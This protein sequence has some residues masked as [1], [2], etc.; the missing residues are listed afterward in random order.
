MVSNNKFM[1]LTLPM[2]HC[3]LL[4]ITC[5]SSTT[6]YQARPS[7]VLQKS[8]LTFWRVRDGLA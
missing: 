8:E 2:F 5:K 7:L 1:N 3:D 4:C 6:V